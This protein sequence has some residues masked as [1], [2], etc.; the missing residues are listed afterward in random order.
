[1]SRYE[2][3]SRASATEAASS[4]MTGASTISATGKTTPP[5]A[6]RCTAGSAWRAMMALTSG[7]SMPMTAQLA[8]SGSHMRNTSR[9]VTVG[10]RLALGMGSTAAG[11]APCDWATGRLY[12]CGR[13]AAESAGRF[14]APQCGANM[15]DALPSRMQASCSKSLPRRLLMTMES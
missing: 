11:S 1:M 12:R 2:A 6:A 7:S 4:M 9:T 15:Q 3:A 14:S 5:Y 8:A 10:R 13:D